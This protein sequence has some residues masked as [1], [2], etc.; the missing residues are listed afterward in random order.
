ML[1]VVGLLTRLVAIPVAFN[2]FVAAFKVHGAAFSLEQGGM[3]YALT[4]GVVA[5]AYSSWAG[6]VVGGWISLPQQVPAPSDG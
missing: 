4:L 5:A 1:L 6:T 3:E 2:M